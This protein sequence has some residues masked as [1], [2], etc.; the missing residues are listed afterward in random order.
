MKK[1]LYLI[2]ILLVSF[3]CSNDDDGGSKGPC[4]LYSVFVSEDCDCI[5]T[6]CRDLY[7]ISETEYERLLETQQNS[8]EDCIYI[9]SESNSSGLF[10]GYMFNLNKGHCP[11]SGGGPLTG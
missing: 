10:E 2:L 9:E 6:D 3:N 5:D 8:T 1:L 11:V 4:Y 7:F